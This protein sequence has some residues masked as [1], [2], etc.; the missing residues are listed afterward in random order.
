MPDPAM[1]PPSSGYSPS[2]A[3]PPA[4]ILVSARLRIVVAR[5]G[6]A[7]ASPCAKV[8]AAHA[9]AHTKN[10]VEIIR[11]LIAASLYRLRTTAAARSNADA[12]RSEA[13]SPCGRTPPRAGGGD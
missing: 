6:V 8:G 1:K 11:R 10:H 12:R 3:P 4:S 9:H 5:P 2:G 13:S 7:A